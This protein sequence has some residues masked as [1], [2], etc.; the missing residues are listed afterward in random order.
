M[1]AGRPTDY[2]P[3]LAGEICDRLSAGVSLRKICLEDAMPGQTTVYR[4]LRQND[5]FRQQYTHARE[6]QAETIFDECLDIADDGT[7]DWMVDKEEDE[8]FRYNGDAVQRSKLRIEA[9]KWMAG[10]LAPK[11]YGEKV[12][13]NHTGEVALRKAAD[14]SDDDLIAEAGL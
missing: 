13:L 2:T 9:R 11:K 14:L 5:E 6:V 7:N 3:E 1:S 4:W 12:E 8:G 10:K